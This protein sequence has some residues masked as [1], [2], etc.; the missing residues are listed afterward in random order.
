MHSVALLFK[1]IQDLSKSYK[2]KHEEKFHKDKKPKPKIDTKKD[3]HKDPSKKA[4]L[5][6]RTK[7]VELDR[8][9]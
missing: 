6:H 2:T 1:K 9:T 8:W 5:K 4:I 7:G 3:F